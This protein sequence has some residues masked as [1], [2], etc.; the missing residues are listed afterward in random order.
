MIFADEDPGAGA[1]GHPAQGNVIEGEVI[2]GPPCADGE[3]ATVVTETAD[4]A[5]GADVEVVINI[6]VNTG[7]DGVDY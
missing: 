5:D 3:F 7:T 2:E 6:D 4:G 1:E